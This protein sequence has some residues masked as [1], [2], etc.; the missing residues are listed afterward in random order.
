MDGLCRNFLSVE[1][2]IQVK[3]TRRTGTLLFLVSVPLELA[4]SALL[5]LPSALSNIRELATMYFAMYKYK[6]K[7]KF[8]SD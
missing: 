6:Y 7:Y 8:L 3:T 2:G 4:L 1:Q 5:A